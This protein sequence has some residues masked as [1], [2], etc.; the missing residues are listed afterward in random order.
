VGQLE[1]S[2]GLNEIDIEEFRLVTVQQ[3]KRMLRCDD[4]TLQE[5]EAVGALPRSTCGFYSYAQV[6]RAMLGRYSN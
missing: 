3:A 2:V 5:L 1:V 4:A 6:E